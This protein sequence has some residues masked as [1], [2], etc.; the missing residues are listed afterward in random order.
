MPHGY[1]DSHDH[2]TNVS[3]VLHEELEIF[4]RLV[5]IIVFIDHQQFLIIRLQ[6]P[7]S[8]AVILS[9]SLFF[10]LALNFLSLVSPDVDWVTALATAVLASVARQSC[11]PLKPWHLTKAALSIL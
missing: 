8:L 10:Q 4:L 2:G 7:L 11:S 6:K 9:Y 5:P 1:T 3:K